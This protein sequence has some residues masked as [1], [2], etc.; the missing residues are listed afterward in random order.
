MVKFW[1]LL[2][3]CTSVFSY[4]QDQKR[5][6]FFSYPSDGVD[7]ALYALSQITDDYEIHS[8]AYNPKIEIL[9]KKNA[10]H[11]LYY[12][13]SVD[14]LHRDLGYYDVEND[15]LLFMLRDYRECFY[16][17]AKGEEQRMLDIAEATYEATLPEL[18]FSYFYD[19]LLYHLWPNERK[20]LVYYEDLIVNPKHE[21]E[22]IAAFLDAKN[23]LTEVFTANLPFL[24]KEKKFRRFIDP[25]HPNSNISKMSHEF[26]LELEAKTI[27]RTEHPNLQHVPF[28]PYIQRY[29][30]SSN[31]ERF[32]NIGVVD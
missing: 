27:K 23:Q 19:F 30:A 15:Y 11:K 2:F 4:S 8:T 1:A 28:L 14:F 24:K 17:M 29:S 26:L 12:F 16:Q 13:S 10:P 32:K 25:K 9:P 31:V 7:W 18:R 20:H 22:K 6:L 3:F 5:I 21:L